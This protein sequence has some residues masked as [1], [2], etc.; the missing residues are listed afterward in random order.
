MKKRTGGGNS[1]FPAVQVIIKSHAPASMEPGAAL[2]QKVL[3]IWVSSG[4][5]VQGFSIEA[6]EYTRNDNTKRVT[7][8][9]MEDLR[10]NMLSRFR[11]NMH[12]GISPLGS[13]EELGIQSSDPIGHRRSKKRPKG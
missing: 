3:E 11:G 10:V 13:G 6:V 2:L 1:P 9:E 12:V 5:V 8:A 4:E 7:G